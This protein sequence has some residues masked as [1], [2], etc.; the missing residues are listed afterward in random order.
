MVA[1]TG[2]GSASPTT[3]ELYGALRDWLKAL[4]C[5][6]VI[7]GWF[8]FASAGAG[9]CNYPV[10]CIVPETGRIE[11]SSASYLEGTPLRIVFWNLPDGSTFDSPT[12]G[13][14]NVL[15]DLHDRVFSGD[16]SLAHWFPV[17]GSAQ[18]N[19]IDPHWEWYWWSGADPMPLG[20]ELF[21]TANVRIGPDE[22]PV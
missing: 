18:F 2:T 12:L 13:G 14:W 19:L 22:I 1:Q 15:F 16:A 10:A 4:G 17:R 7:F 5:K 9:N 20:A 21:L 6:T 3:R 11:E 8:D